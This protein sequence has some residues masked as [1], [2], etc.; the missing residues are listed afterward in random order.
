MQ[1]PLLTSLRALHVVFLQDFKTDQSTHIGQAYLNFASQ[2]E[3][4]ERSSGAV[5]AALHACICNHTRYP[6][7]EQQPGLS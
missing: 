2:A 7:L 6:S 3:G 1:V 4:K 5:A